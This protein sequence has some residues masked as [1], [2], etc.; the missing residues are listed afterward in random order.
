MKYKGRGFVHI[1]DN[2]T[3]KQLEKAEKEIPKL[4]MMKAQR[5][6]QKKIKDS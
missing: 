6:Y 5:E 3:K 2:A 4:A 1:I